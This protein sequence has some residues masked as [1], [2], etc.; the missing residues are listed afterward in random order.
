MSFLSRSFTSL[1]DGWTVTALA[2]PT[3]DGLDLRAV[4]AVVPGCVHTDLLRAG[5][6]DEPFDGDNESLQQWIGSTTWRYSTTFDWTDDGN[7]R[8]DLVALGLDTVATIE[9][10]GT[11]IGSTQNQ[12]RSYRFDLRGVVR[13][14][15]NE[16]AVTFE[17]PVV[18]AERR[19]AEHGAWPHVNHHPFN[20]LRKSASN[21]GWDWGIDVATSGI[22]Q[23]IGIESWSGARISAVRPLVDVDGTDG[24]ATVHVAVERD[25]SQDAARSGALTLAVRAGDEAAEARIAADETEASIVVRVPDARL[26]WP[27]GHGDQPLYP[28]TVAIDGTPAEWRGRIGFRTIEVDTG[29]DASGNR[30]VVRV[31][32]EDVLIRGV[33]WIPD[34]AFITEMTRD[35]YVSRFAD[36]VE[37]NVNLLRVWGGGIYESEDFYEL[38]DELGVLVWQDFLFACA[39]YSEDDWLAVE[40]EAEAREQITRLS[41]HAS[42]AIWN[43]NN[44]NIWGYVEWG[45]R[46]TLGERAWGD[47]YYRHLLPGLVAELDP[48]RSYSPASPFSFVDYAHPNDERNGTMHIWDVWN[49]RDY[50]AYRDYAPRFVSEFGFQ[51]PPAWTTLTDVVHD[52]P[53]DPYGEQMLVH[54]KAEAGNL[55]LERGMAGHLPVPATIEDWHWATQLNQAQAIRFGVEHFRSLTPHNTGTVLWQLNDDWP[56]VSWAAVDFNGHRK[57]L[58]F[59]MRDAYAPRLATIQ[60]RNGGLALVLVNDTADAVATTARVSRLAFDGTV[61]VEQD[62]DVRVDARG[63][64]TFELAA[65]LAG[66]GDP[67]R[68]LIAAIVDGFPRAIWNGA[69]VVDQKLDPAAL[70][71]SATRTEGGYRVVVTA[72]SYLREVFLAV[73]RVDCDASVDAGLVTLLPGESVTLDV[74]SSS[75]VDPAAF[76]DALV[77]RSANDL[78]STKTESPGILEQ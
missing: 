33:N 27:I 77:L 78:L 40:V 76:T 48:T 8:H 69:E 50:S 25:G 62:I 32:G 61:L 38:A 53:L 15:A 13:E 49:E 34:H 70:E 5:L 19:D 52:A 39:A 17:A 58:W 30:F 6:I 59:A 10:N 45:W 22:W 56:V 16:L 75:D 65:D 12:H 36:A 26:W 42:L 74:A 3:P 24:V 73:D 11:V 29:A 21:F 44:E 14:G 71:A 9:L 54:Q 37:A 7:V 60:P 51:G 23:P 64:A 43:G 47:G 57:P 4:P 41:Q 18:E 68:E 1:H 20:Q 46:R 2:G 55:K 66:F 72:H 67:A 31:N 63:A 35:R 28:V